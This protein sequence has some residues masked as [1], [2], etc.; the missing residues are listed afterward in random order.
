VLSLTKHTP[1]QENGQITLPR[2]WRERYG[3]KKGDIVSFEETP[4][5]ALKVLP[6]VSIGLQAL[7][8]IREALKE[9]EVSLDDLLKSGE[10]IR[11]DIFDKTYK[12][13]GKDA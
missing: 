12:R 2:K 1:L 4:D 8:Q 11:Q 13:S 10:D 7:E 5:G 3:L 9:K 6:R